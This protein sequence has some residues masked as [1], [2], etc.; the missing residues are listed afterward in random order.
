MTIERIRELSHG[1]LFICGCCSTC[2]HYHHHSFS[3]N[4]LKG[5][6]IFDRFLCELVFCACF[7]KLINGSVYYTYIII[8]INILLQ[9]CLR[10][11]KKNNKNN[12]YCRRFY[13]FFADVCKFVRMISRKVLL[14]SIWDFAGCFVMLIKE[15]YLIW[16]L[17]HK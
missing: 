13:P 12:T 6:F 17:D 5:I 2:A 15:P 7:N 9:S 14:Q 4:F 1:L 3:H 11:T 8:I 10:Q 16:Y